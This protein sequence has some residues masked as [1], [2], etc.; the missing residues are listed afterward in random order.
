MSGGPLGDVVVAAL[1]KLINPV[2][3]VPLGPAEEVGELVVYA[4]AVLGPDGQVVAQR[5][6][7][8]L[9][10]QA[11][12]RLAA[13]GLPVDDVHVRAVVYVE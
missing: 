2:V 11:G 9:A 13:R 6:A 4:G 10:Q 12:E 8:Q 7:V 1:H 3:A 5:D